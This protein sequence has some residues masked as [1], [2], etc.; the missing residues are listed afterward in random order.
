M[1][2]YFTRKGLEAYRAQ[3]VKLEERLADLQFQLGVACSS[4]GNT[5]HDN[6]AY[7]HLCEDIRVADQRL[8]DAHKVLRDITIFTPPKEV[9][10]VVLGSRVRVVIDGKEETIDIVGYGEGDTSKNRILYEAPLAQAMMLKFP[11]Q[12]VNLKVGDLEQRV[13]IVK[14]S[15]LSEE[16]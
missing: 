11:G 4:A 5:F 13:T 16:D 15:P 8:N 9:T 6:A 14:V 2:N 12:E 1:A 10:R 3:V 7:D